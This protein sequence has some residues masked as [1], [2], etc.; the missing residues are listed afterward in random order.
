MSGLD[1]AR[2]LRDVGAQRIYLDVVDAE[3]TDELVREVVEGRVVPLLDEVCRE[4]DHARLDPWVMRGATVAVGNVSELALA[5]E[6]GARAEVR[7][8]IPAHNTA[9]LRVLGEL[10]ASFAWLS[11]ELSLGQMREL[12]CADVLPV[13]ALVYGRPRLMTCEHCA[14]QVAYDCN[15]DHARCPHRREPHWLVNIDERALPVRTDACGRSRV[16]LDEPLDLIPEA[17]SLAAFGAS[18]LLV[19]ARN[20]SREQA[21]CAIERLSRALLGDGVEREGLAGLLSRGVE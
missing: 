9:A 2:E 4:P 17:V 15:R 19:D 6:R 14:L 13:G 20:V 8:C 11:P 3:M 10:G 21:L 7:P 12:A 18:R 5:R 1:E 16:F